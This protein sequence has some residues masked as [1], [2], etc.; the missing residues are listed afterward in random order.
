MLRKPFVIVLIIIFCVIS[1]YALTW[2][3][4][5]FLLPSFP[6]QDNPTDEQLIANF[7][8][9]QA[10]FKQ[11]AELL[12]AEKD[13]SVVLPLE[14]QCRIDYP[15]SGKDLG[16]GNCPE[17][18]QLFNLLGL[19]F[20]QIDGSSNTLF[21]HIPPNRPID[22]GGST[23]KVYIYSTRDLTQQQKSSVCSHIEANW[24]VCTS[25]SGK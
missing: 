18:M 24:Y 1:I 15:R 2:R 8:Q 7:S 6:L 4:A 22:F 3:A 12:L 19:K 23:L 14:H 13:I 25:N 20:A 21:L 9:H 11:L 10:E 5:L 16:D 17:Y